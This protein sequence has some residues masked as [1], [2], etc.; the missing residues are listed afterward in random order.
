L[1]IM[2]GTRFAG[3]DVSVDSKRTGNLSSDRNIY[4]AIVMVRPRVQLGERWQLMPSFSVGT[5][6]SDLTWEV[7]P[8]I[9]Y[10]AA[11][12]T[13]RFGYRN[14]NYDNEKD[15]DKIDISMRGVLLGIGFVF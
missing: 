6:D 13:F 15:N 4:D 5:G 9:I 8:E 12:L 14:L 10:Q 3:M 11:E 2:A 1:D 7:F